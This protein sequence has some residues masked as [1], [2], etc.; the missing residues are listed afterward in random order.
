MLFR[1]VCAIKLQTNKLGLRYK[2]KNKYKYVYKSKN[3]YTVAFRIDGKDVRFG[4]FD[5]EEEA[6][7]V[8]IEKAKELGRVV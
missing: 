8:A 7:K 3:K 5:S 4:T 1:S 6:A 2:N